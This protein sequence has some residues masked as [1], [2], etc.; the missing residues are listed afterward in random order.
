LSVSGTAT[1]SSQATFT[2]L[3]TVLGA[4]GTI[5]MGKPT[6]SNPG[7]AI[8]APAGTFAWIALAGNGNTIDA[9]DL[10]LFQDSVGNAYIQQNAVGGSLNLQTSGATRISINSSGAIVCNSATGG[11]QGAGTV[12]ATGYYLNGSNQ[13]QTGTFTGTLTGCTT[14]PTA[15]FTYAIAGRIATIYCSAGLEATSNTTACTITGMPAVLTPT[16]TQVAPC[17]G[18]V[19]SSNNVAA[20]YTDIAGTTLTFLVSATSGG[21]GFTASG[22]KGINAEWSVTYALG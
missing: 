14:A 4:S 2:Q 3:V 9:T 21:N 17:Y 6:N 1:F 18:I 15:T 16:N 5:V 19:N 7:I 10:E 22:N 13:F 8:S 20:G 11:A 12:N